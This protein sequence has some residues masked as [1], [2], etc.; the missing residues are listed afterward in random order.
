MTADIIRC[1]EK[2]WQNS[3]VGSREKI[4]ALFYNGNFSDLTITFAGHDIE[5][6]AH[7]LIMAVSSSIFEGMLFG[8]MANK[9]SELELPFDNPEAFKIVLGS[10]YEVGIETSDID[11]ALEVYMLADKYFMEQLEKECAQHI[12][13][14]LNNENVNKVLEFATHYNFISLKETC[15]EALKTK[16][17]SDIIDSSKILLVLQTN[18]CQELLKSDIKISH[19]VFQDS[20]RY[21]SEILCDDIVME[22]LRRKCCR[23]PGLRKFSGCVSAKIVNSICWAFSETLGDICELRLSFTN[24]QQAKEVISVLYDGQFTQWL[25]VHLQC[26][27]IPTDLL[28]HLP[29]NQLMYQPDLFI[30]DVDN[31][32]IEWVVS[33][34]RSLMPIDSCYDLICF[35]KCELTFS[36]LKLLMVQLA[37]VNVEYRGIRM[38]SPE[39]PSYKEDEIKEWARSNLPQIDTSSVILLFDRNEDIRGW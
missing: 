31:H 17:Q 29:V 12:G 7:R 18:W 22:V 16:F 36:G 25:S 13:N 24:H 32:G 38:C 35:P 10:C 27:M 26:N 14:L 37:E 15:F 28:I 33:A 11:V 19:L 30:S 1:P 20:W 23:Y 4:N 9:G 8:P 5:Y 39:L 3:L 34:A 2:P 21:P 6:K